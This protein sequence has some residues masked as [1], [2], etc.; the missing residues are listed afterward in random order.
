MLKAIPT[1]VIAARNIE[2]NRYRKNKY[3]AEHIIRI[4]SFIHSFSN[5]FSVWLLRW[6]NFETICIF[7]SL[8]LFEVRAKMKAGFA[9]ITRTTV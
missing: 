7:F 5:D 2:G 8:S 4:R 9:Q 6:K 1:W 3:V